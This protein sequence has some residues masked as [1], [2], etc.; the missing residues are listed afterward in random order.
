MAKKTFIPNWYEDKKI[1][2][3]NKKIKI[4]IIVVSIANIFL[5][6]FILNISNKT[7]NIDKERLNGNSNISNVEA[8]KIVKHDITIIEKYKEV[9]DFSEKNNLSFKNIIITKDNLE[10]DIEVKSNEEYIHA[11]RCI[12]NHYSIKKLIPNIKNEGNFNFKV[13]IEV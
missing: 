10:I 7:K 3:R 1:A 11:I 2:I 5:I 12:E 6:S 13:M 4:C 9:S 8:V